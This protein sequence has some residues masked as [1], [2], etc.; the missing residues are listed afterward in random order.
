MNYTIFKKSIIADHSAAYQINTRT[1]ILDAER[2]KDNLIIYTFKRHYLDKY[3]CIDKPSTTYYL[4]GAF[5][6][7]GGLIY[8]K[9][10]RFDYDVISFDEI[11]RIEVEATDKS[12]DFWKTWENRQE[13]IERRA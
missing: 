8:H 11:E 10:N 4:R 13:Q 1:A 2:L 5:N 6:L 3:R 7:H 12:A 9:K